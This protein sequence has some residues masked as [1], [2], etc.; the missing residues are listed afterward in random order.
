M[1]LLPW[2]EHLGH[3]DLRLYAIE[4]RGQLTALAPLY[5]AENSKLQFLGTGIS[6]YLDGLCLPGFG[7]DLL[8]QIDQQRRGRTGALRE[9][10]RTQTLT[11]ST[12]PQRRAF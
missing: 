7:D 6:D 1:W 2:W 8:A 12:V 10:S 9:S 3:G 11:L 4:D 5:V